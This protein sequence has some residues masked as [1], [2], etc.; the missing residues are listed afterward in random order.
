MTGSTAATGPERIVDIAVGYMAAK[1]LSRR[2]GSGSS[3]R[4]PTGR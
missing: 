1:Q 3:A 2:A 4:S